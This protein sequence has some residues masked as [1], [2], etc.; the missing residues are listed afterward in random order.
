MARI[1][2]ADAKTLFKDMKCPKKRKFEHF[3]FDWN[4][5]DYS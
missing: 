3:D 5:N 2:E 4:L 1:S